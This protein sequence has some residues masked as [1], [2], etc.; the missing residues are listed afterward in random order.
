MKKKEERLEKQMSEV[1]SENKKLVEPLQRAREQLDE[2]QRQLANY[3]K[4]KQSFAVS[5]Q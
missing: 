1:M 4:D 3:E 2:L 5:T